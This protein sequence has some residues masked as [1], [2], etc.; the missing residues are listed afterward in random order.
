MKIYV[1]SSWRNPLQPHIV[2][3]LRGDGHQVYDFRNPAPGNHG[4]DWKEIDAGWQSW[5]P[6]QYREAL[7][8]PVAVEGYAQDFKAMEWAE[9]FVLVQP[10]GRSAHLELGWACG[11]GKVTAVLLADGEPELMIKMADYICCTTDELLTAMRA[12]AKEDWEAWLDDDGGD[13]R[14]PGHAGTDD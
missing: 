14:R 12:D 7:M 13:P 5:T 6:S 9:A 10:C 1:A 3:L 4:F 11:Q 2:Q 8:D